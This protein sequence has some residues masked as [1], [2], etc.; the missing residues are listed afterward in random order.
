MAQ[1]KINSLEELSK[2]SDRLPLDVYEDIN[3]RVGDWVLSGGNT[4]DPYV[5]QQLRY[6]ENYLNFTSL[7]RSSGKKIIVLVGASGS[8]KTTLAKYLEEKH[9]IP[10]LV[11]TTTRQPR[12]G[13]AYGIDY[14]FTTVT[15]F[16]TL[17]KVEYNIYNNNFYGLTKREVDDKLMAHDVVCVV[18]EVNGLKALKKFYPNEVLSVCLEVS[19]DD[20]YQRMKQRGDSLEAIAERI[21]SAILN[22]EFDYKEHCDFA[23]PTTTLEATKQELDRILS[24]ILK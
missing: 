12:E 20:M 18:L 2:Y 4:D 22:G 23:I 13:E 10:K 19:L 6:A 24:S 21:T 17:E 9:G 15:Q 7:D 8:G 11:T 1:I 14:H 5:K 3:K 16:Q